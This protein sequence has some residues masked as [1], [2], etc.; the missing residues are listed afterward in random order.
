MRITGLICELQLYNQAK[1]LMTCVFSGTDI[2]QVTYYYVVEN[3]NF[4]KILKRSLPTILIA[5]NGSRTNNCMNVVRTL[6]RLNMVKR[7]RR[8]VAETVIQC[9]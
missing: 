6:T 2:P 1:I 4:L 5:V 9:N 8:F 7:V 3:K